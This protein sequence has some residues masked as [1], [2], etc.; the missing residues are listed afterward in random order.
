MLEADLPSFENRRLVVR[1]WMPEH[2][3]AAGL[4]VRVSRVQFD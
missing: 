1:A 2:L 4:Y 3:H